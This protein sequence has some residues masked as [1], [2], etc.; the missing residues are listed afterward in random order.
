MGAI[1]LAIESGNLSATMNEIDSVWNEVVPNIPIERRFIDELYDRMYI[2]E[3]R[4]N[5]LFSGFAGLAIVLSCM[6][7][8]G[9][10]SYT[11]SRRKKEIGIRKVAGASVLDIVF[12]LLLQF[13]KPVLLA[14]VVGIPIALFFIHD[15]L[16]GFAYRISLYDYACL[17]PAVLLAVLIVAWLT[18]LFHALLAARTKPFITLRAE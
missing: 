3:E 16:K 5:Q 4:G 1:T 13:A 11:I 15:W 6:G 12:L 17:F 8:Y 9:L 18:V 10:S 7:L 14:G 2:R